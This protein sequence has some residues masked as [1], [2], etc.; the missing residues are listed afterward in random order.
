MGNEIRDIQLKRRNQLIKIYTKRLEEI[1]KA[2][3]TAA[4]SGGDIRTLTLQQNKIERILKELKKEFETFSN[5]AIKE[6][7]TLSQEEQKEKLNVL[8]LALIGLFSLQYPKN[9]TQI[10]DSQVLLYTQLNRISNGITKKVN[11]FFKTDFTE[12]KQVVNGLTNLIP[13]DSGI[14]P[15]NN[16]AQLRLISSEVEAARWKTLLNTLEKNL[17][18]KDI[19][20]IPYYDKNGKIVRRVKAGTYAE[21]LARTVTAKTYRDAAKSG[22]METFGEFGDLVEILGRSKVDCSECKPFE[23]QI[24]SLEGKT[25]GYTTIKEAQEQGLFHPN[26]IHSF[27]VTDRV[28]DEYLKLN[29]NPKGQNAI[30]YLLLKQSGEVQKAFYRKDIGNIDLIWGDETQ[31]LKHIIT[32]RTEQNINIVEFLSDLSDV[33]EK[34]QLVRTNAKGR[35]EIFLHG[36]MAIIEPKNINGKQTFLLTAFKRRK[37]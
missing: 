11:I 10:K 37:P 36:K 2:I 12:Q 7:Y 24:L 26:C 32:R 29:Q 17:K 25:K 33:I 4:K 9:K 8:G 18:D 13:K 22:I 6:T 23:G 14:A 19:F 34:G 20:S 16:L 15:L 21:M 27:A 3:F 1:K 5:E 28:I 35:Y 31:G 30:N